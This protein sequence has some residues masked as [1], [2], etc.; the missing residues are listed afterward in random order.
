MQSEGYEEK[1]YIIISFQNF[2][3]DKR[4]GLLMLVGMEQA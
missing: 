2:L 4:I 1:V 3:S